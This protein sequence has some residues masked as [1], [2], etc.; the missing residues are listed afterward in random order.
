[1]DEA[2]KAYKILVWKNEGN[3]TLG[4]PIPG[5]ENNIKIDFKF[6]VGGIIGFVTTL[7]YQLWVPRS[8]ILLQD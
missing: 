7:L 4:L 3:R 5:F 1:M 8:I 6:M 2:K